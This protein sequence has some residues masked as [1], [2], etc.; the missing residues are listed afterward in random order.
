MG[1]V[2]SHGRLSLLSY[3]KPG[4]APGAD[5]VSQG[6]G[7]VNAQP[8]ENA[9]K[10]PPEDMEPSAPGVLPGAYPKRN[11]NASWLK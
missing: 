10:S 6:G 5:G 1:I 4:R 9:S 2:L 11:K 7:G 8:E 3:S